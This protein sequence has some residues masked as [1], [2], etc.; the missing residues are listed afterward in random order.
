MKAPLVRPFPWAAWPAAVVLFAAGA[1]TG[2][3]AWGAA[4]RA[5]SAPVP[6]SAQDPLVTASYVAA[7]LARMAPR[8]WQLAAG[9][10]WQPPVGTAF[11]VTQ[12]T[13]APVGQLPAGALVDA[14]AGAAVAGTTQPLPLDHL[15]VVVGTGVT[16]AAQGGPVSLWLGA[17]SGG[18]VPAGGPAGG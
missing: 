12:G 5:P 9:Q 11:L 16:L 1:V 14:T 13:A 2:K 10:M 8:V 6:G 15:L 18:A 7:S 17:G 3:V 4:G